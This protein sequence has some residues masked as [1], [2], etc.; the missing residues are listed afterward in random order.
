MS[1]LHVGPPDE[2][3]RYVLGDHPVAAGSEGILYRASVTTT[4]GARLDVAIKMLHPRF[5]GRIEEW[6]RRWSEQVE[7]LRSLQTPGVV[8]VRDGF[9]GPPPHTVGSA[10]VASGRTLYLVMNWVDGT[11]LDQW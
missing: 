8:P 3:D 6:Q 5:Q 2:P 10:D 1:D 4:S 9:I 11:P 7:L